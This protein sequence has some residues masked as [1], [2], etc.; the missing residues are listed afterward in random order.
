MFELLKAIGGLPFDSLLLPRGAPAAS[1]VASKVHQ[2][3]G[4]F[5]QL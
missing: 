3:E 5:R 2:E 4:F 1:T